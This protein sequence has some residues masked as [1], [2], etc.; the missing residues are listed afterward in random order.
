MD[1]SV[2]FARPMPAEWNDLLLKAS[3][4]LDGSPT[5]TLQHVDTL[6]NQTSELDNEQLIANLYYADGLVL[7]GMYR[8]L[9]QADIYEQYVNISGIQIAKH[10]INLGIGRSQ[11]ALPFA[12]LSTYPVAIAMKNLAYEARDAINPPINFLGDVLTEVTLDRKLNDGD[13]LVGGNI[14]SKRA[15]FS[16]VIGKLPMPQVIGRNASAG[17]ED[18]FAMV[19]ER[20]EGIDRSSHLQ[21]LVDSD[22]FANSRMLSKLARGLAQLRLDEFNNKDYL[23]KLVSRNNIGEL[24]F[25]SRVLASPP[26]TKHLTPSDA[27]NVH[28]VLHLQ[29]HTCPAVQVQGLIPLM[30][31]FMTDAYTI[32]SD[33]N[34]SLQS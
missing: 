28:S 19:I 3:D 26:P 34:Q 33:Y 14:H 21:E 20:T 5:P 11:D 8:Q 7:C 27:L 6:W 32:A 16:R 24:V 18:I 10:S 29:R 17:A 25:D 13:P 30:L 1:S 15:A 9:C 31:R 2:K 12:S 22:I 4:I 23:N